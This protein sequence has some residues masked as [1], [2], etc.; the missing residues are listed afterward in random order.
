MCGLNGI[1][2]ARAFALQRKFPF[3][4]C[5]PELRW[6][7]ASSSLCS[8]IQS[9]TLSLTT[10]G[11]NLMPSFTQVRA[12]GWNTGWLPYVTQVQQGTQPWHHQPK[13]TAHNKELFYLE[14]EEAMRVNPKVVSQRPSGN[15]HKFL[16]HKGICRK[17]ILFCFSSKCCC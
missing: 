16:L 9:R 12:E 8:Y 6:H 10:Q 5:V 14:I 3:L 11:E 17:S 7:R 4:V 15:E 13:I 2:A 1:T